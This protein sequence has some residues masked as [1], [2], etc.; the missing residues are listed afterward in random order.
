EHFDASW[1]KAHQNR[2]ARLHLWVPPTPG[3]PG[4]TIGAAWQFAHLVGA[5]RGA[6]M[7]HAFY[8]GQPPSRDEIT[9]ALEA[10]DI[11]SLEIGS[12]ATAD[13]RD[14]VADLMAFVIARNGII[15]L[16]QG[17]AETGPRALGHRSIF[18]NPCDPDAREQLNERVK[19][20]EAIRP[21]APMATLETAHDY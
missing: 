21:L 20:R 7:T 1:F 15:A 19:Y 3:D 9:A 14:A 17:A 10:D 12:I 6:P 11:A 16:C 4:V 2:D 13:G 5:P 8:C 18:A